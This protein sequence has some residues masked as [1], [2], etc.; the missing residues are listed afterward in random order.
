[1]KTPIFRNGSCS[2]NRK[3]SRLITTLRPVPHRLS[4]STFP[5]A[6]SFHL[7]TALAAAAAGL[8]ALQLQRSHPVSQGMAP[9]CTAERHHVEP[10]CAPGVG[11]GEGRLSGLGGGEPCRHVL[12]SPETG[13]GGRGSD[14][15]RERMLSLHICK[16]IKRRY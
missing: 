15:A 9:L 11:Q 3:C 1:M 16:C 6:S 14:T 13:A 12:H 10:V 2:I 4:T 5:S 7:P 8:Q